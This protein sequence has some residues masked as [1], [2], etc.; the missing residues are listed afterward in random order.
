MLLFIYCYQVSP[1]V[2]TQVPLPRKSGVDTVSPSHFS[3]Q[4]VHHIYVCTMCVELLCCH[5]G[6]RY[7]S[8]YSNYRNT[9]YI[10]CVFQHRQNGHVITAG[11]S[12]IAT[13]IY[14]VFQVF[15]KTILGGGACVCVC[16]RDSV[17]FSY[18]TGHLLQYYSIMI[19]RIVRKPG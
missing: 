15:A 13:P 3:A 5:Y 19:N 1:T 6:A 14:M 17:F 11:I 12:T 9:S 10:D 18:S 7:Y 8:K 16:V 2:L 4:G